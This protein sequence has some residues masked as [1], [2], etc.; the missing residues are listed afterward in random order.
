MEVST[1]I[2]K[3]TS[4][5]REAAASIQEAA[6]TDDVRLQN[7]EF[8]TNVA[9]RQMIKRAAAG[10]DVINRSRVHDIVVYA[11]AFAKRKRED[12]AGR[13]ASGISKKRKG[14]GGDTKTRIINMV[15]SLWKAACATEYLSQDAKRGAD[16]FR[17][18]VSGILYATKRGVCMA[19]GL[20][21]VPEVP[22]ISDQLPTLRSHDATEAARQL[23]SSS[24]RGLCCLHRSIASFETADADSPNYHDVKQA[25]ESA[26]TVSAQLRA[27]CA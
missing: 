27:Y 19:N 13:A 20:E 2:D 15:L 16:S 25:F 8:C 17:P 26:A 24:H 22:F 14:F 23:Q 18:F 10:G 3:L 6:S 9:I 5:K 11:H 7:P 12:A 1:V 4:T 21:I